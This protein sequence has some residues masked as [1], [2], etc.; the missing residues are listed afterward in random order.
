MLA[1]AVQIW[2]DADSRMPHFGGGGWY[3]IAA[4]DLE[5]GDEFRIIRP[6]GSFHHDTAGVTSWISDSE[7]FISNGVPT[8]TVA[9]PGPHSNAAWI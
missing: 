9:G 2:R 3:N 4:N 7:Y 5:P 8:Y 6:D 1:C